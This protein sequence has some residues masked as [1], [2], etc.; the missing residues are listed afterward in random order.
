MSLANL[1]HLLELSALQALLEHR[2]LLLVCFA[3]W[4]TEVFNELLSFLTRE[5]PRSFCPQKSSLFSYGQTLFALYL[6]SCCS[7]IQSSDPLSSGVSP[8][9]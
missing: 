3:F 7:L 5:Q 2:E 6:L 9:L 1:L 4:A 8:L